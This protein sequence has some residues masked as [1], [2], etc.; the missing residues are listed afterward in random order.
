MARGKK[1]IM[2]DTVEDVSVSEAVEATAAAVENVFSVI[3]EDAKEEVT[4]V[5]TAV[6]ADLSEMSAKTRAEFAA[7]AE[8]LKRYLVG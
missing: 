1:L 4:D 7:G 8:A 6:E 3:V 2:S 5:V